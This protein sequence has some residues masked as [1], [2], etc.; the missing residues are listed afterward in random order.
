MRI[1]GPLFKDEEESRAQ[2]EV[3]ETAAELQP[4]IGAKVRILT[5][6]HIGKRGRVIGVTDN[7]LLLEIGTSKRLSS[8][9]A[10]DV[11]M[12]RRRRA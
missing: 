2:W 9:S 5:G 3:L 6:P 1:D 12:V 10:D 8:V 4:R 11:R 7:E